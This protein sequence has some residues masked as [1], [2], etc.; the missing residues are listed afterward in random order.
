MDI[1]HTLFILL[2][3]DIWVVATFV[4]LFSASRNILVHAS[5]LMC[6]GV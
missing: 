6:T 3:M 5:W 2:L 4:I 1:F